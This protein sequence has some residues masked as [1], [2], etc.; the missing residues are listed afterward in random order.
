MG[1][2]TES[3]DPDRHVDPTDK[4][5]AVGPEHKLDMPFV[6]PGA[7]PYDK[8]VADGPADMYHECKHVKSHYVGP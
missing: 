2:T 7:G 3:A 6:G 8:T 1:D 5:V 4:L